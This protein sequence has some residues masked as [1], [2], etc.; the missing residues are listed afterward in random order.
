[1]QSELDVARFGLV[2]LVAQVD[3]GAQAVER[4]ARPGD[5][6]H[7]IGWIRRHRAHLWP[8]RAPVKHE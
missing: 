2:E 7:E 3:H 4:L 5:R 6:A 1:V 8:I